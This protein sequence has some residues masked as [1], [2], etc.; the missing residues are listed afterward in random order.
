MIRSIVLSIQLVAS[1][2]IHRE[3]GVY[4]T[5]WLFPP[6]GQE[7]MSSV[8]GSV[9]NRKTTVEWLGI[10]WPFQQFFGAG[11]IAR[12]DLSMSFGHTQ[13]QLWVCS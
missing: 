11:P 4:S 9:F 6:S 7:R 2:S 10:S 8:P 1:P 13:A 5:N 12:A 3:C